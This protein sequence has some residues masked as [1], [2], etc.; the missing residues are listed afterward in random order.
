MSDKLIFVYTLG[1]SGSQNDSFY[2]K[3]NADVATFNNLERAN[4]YVGTIHQIMQ[5]Q[6]AWPL[7][8]I[9]YKTLKTGID[10]FNRTIKSICDNQKVK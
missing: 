1:C 9:A 7:Y 6:S 3:V 4:L 5:A 2:L 10:T 8:S